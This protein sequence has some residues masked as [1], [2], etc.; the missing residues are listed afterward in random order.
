MERYAVLRAIGIVT[1]L[2][3]LYRG[4][5]SSIPVDDLIAMLAIAL[6][7]I[8]LGNDLKKNKEVNEVV[9]QAQKQETELEKLITANGLGL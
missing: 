4:L 3:S 7:I 9:E 6:A 2:L 5:T 8:W 1:T